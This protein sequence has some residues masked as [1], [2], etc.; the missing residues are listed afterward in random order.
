[1]PPEQPAYHEHVLDASD[2]CMSCHRIVRVERQDPTRGGLTREYETHHERHRDHTVV[3]YGPADTVGEQQGTFCSKCGTESPWDRY[4]DDHRT[5]AYE[6][7]TALGW[8]DDAD[9]PTTTPCQERAVSPAKFRELVKATIRTLD[10]KGVTLHRKTLAREALRRRR[11]GAHV[12]DCLGEATEAA[13]RRA[14]TRDAA[15]ADQTRGE[16]PA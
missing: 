15:D 3:D 10:E 14:V 16:L 8:L 13:I 12:D 5:G 2:V 11:D 6:L 9:E 1:M 7:A 4:W